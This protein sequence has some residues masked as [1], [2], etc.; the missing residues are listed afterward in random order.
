MRVVIHYV[1]KQGAILVVENVEYLSGR[2]SEQEL[3][4][5]AKDHLNS[6]ELSQRCVAAIE[7]AIIYT[8][9][10]SLRFE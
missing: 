5:F 4:A 1:G 9:A 3:Q 6:L 8:Q 2:A 7:T 10:T